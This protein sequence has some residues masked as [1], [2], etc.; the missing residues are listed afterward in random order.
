MVQHRG[1]SRGRIGMQDCSHHKA[2]LGMGL[3]QSPRLLELCLSERRQPAAKI[4]GELVDDPIMRAG[5][6]GAVERDIR[7]D[8][9]V[10]K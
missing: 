4:Q 2:M 5:I 7:L 1:V 8:V 10:V 9:P 6:N 3:S